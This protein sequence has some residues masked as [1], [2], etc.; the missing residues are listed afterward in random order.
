MS[1]VPYGPECFDPARTAGSPDLLRQLW[2]AD[3]IYRVSPLD[4]CPFDHKRRDVRSGL[5]G[6]VND[7]SPVWGDGVYQTQHLW[8]I[9]CL[10]L[11]RHPNQVRFHPAGQLDHG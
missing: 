9:G 4:T 2:V 6:C 3:N 7:E 5:A 8:P 10:R 11:L 1:G